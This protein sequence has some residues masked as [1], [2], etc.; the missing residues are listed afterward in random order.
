[1][2]ERIERG[3]VR[4]ADLGYVGKIR[5]CLIVSVPTQEQERVLSALVP[6]TTSVRGTRFEV[7]IDKP[8]LKPGAFD[9]QGIIT[10]PTVKLGRKL[11]QLTSEE[12]KLVDAA[13]QVWLGLKP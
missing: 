13:V 12:M 1:M 5:P 3:D 2:P 7:V 4:L 8:F 10:L 6:H 9:A 11:G